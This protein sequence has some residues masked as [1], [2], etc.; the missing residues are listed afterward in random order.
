MS[1][2]LILPLALLLDLILGEPK[3]FHPLVGFGYLVERAEQ[4]LN[5]GRCRIGWGLLAWTLLVVPCVM[6]VYLLDQWLG[7]WWLSLF[8]GWLALGWQSLRQHGRWV[9]EALL[10]D[11]LAAARTKLGWI[12]SRD[13]AALDTAAIS[14]GG[15]ESVLENGSDAVFAALFWLALAG[16]PGVVLYRLSNTLDAMWGYRNQRFERFGK[17]AARVDDGLNYF[18]ARL[19]ALT[20]A[21]AGAFMPAL[22]AWRLQA[23]Q[24]YSPNAGVVMAAGAG[25]LRLQL[26]GDAVY[27]GTV[28]PR[29]TL[30]DG[31]A[32]QAADVQRSIQLVDRGVLLWGATALLFG[33]AG[34]ATL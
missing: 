14:R 13:T 31:A 1:F 4:L 33:L 29:P 25:A 8:F 22:R 27:H 20:Y 30:G 19:T 21:L 24:W 5:R 11:D 12:V 26:G 32:P 17:W 7:G 34:L 9:A 10:A 6:G 23:G 28:K 18:P 3:R 16:A 15:V 2:L